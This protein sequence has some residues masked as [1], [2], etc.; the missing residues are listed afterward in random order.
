V[1]DVALT[2]PIAPAGAAAPS[3]QGG[4]AGRAPASCARPPL[5]PAGRIAPMQAAPTGST[6]ATADAHTAEI[7]RQ[8]IG[9]RH[10]NG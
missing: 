8:R 9:S 4:L 1:T 2:A 7:D 5:C 3:D 6:T 10:L